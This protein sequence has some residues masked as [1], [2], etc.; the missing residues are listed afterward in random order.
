[1][2]RGV[3]FIRQS[4]GDGARAFFQPAGDV[5]PPKP[6]RVRWSVNVFFAERF[7]TAIEHMTNRNL[8]LDDGACSRVVSCQL[9]VCGDKV[10]GAH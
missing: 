6:T 8:F 9:R 5:I 3:G 4:Q 2:L 10:A 7:T 1:M